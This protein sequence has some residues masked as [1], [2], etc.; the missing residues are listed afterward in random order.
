MFSNRE[1]VSPCHAV[2]ALLRI[3]QHSLCARGVSGHVQDRH[4]IGGAQIAVDGLKLAAQVPGLQ[5]Q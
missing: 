5:T 4:T 2:D 3:H 1:I